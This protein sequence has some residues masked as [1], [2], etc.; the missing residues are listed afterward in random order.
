M[1]YDITWEVPDRIIYLRVYGT[2]DIDEAR[3]SHE[4]FCLMLEDC[5]GSAPVHLIVDHTELERFPGI[6]RDYGYVVHTKPNLHGGWVVA[7]GHNA[8]VRFITR[9]IGSVLRFRV[10]TEETKAAALD[11]LDQMDPTLNEQAAS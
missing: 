11:Y 10:C 3:C 9:L 7:V 2:L 5:D 4:A 8:T 6:W 1:A